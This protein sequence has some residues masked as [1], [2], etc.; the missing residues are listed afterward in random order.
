MNNES[1]GYDSDKK[2]EEY[3]ALARLNIDDFKLSN[4]S[5][6]ID[7]MISGMKAGMDDGSVIDNY[8]PSIDWGLARNGR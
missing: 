3:R 5:D 2:S 7:K 6:P 4:N 1:F 8:R